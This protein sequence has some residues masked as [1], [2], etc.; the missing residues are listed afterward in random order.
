MMNLNSPDKISPLRSFLK[1]RMLFMVGIILFFIIF[2]IYPVL[3]IVGVAFRPSGRFSLSLFQ[4]MFENPVIRESIWNS[5]KIGIMVT[6]L[7]SC[8]S[9]PLA[10][11]FHRYKFP[12]KTLF[13]GLLLLPLIIPPFVGALGIRQVLAPFGSVNLWLLDHQIISNP[14]DFLGESGLFGVIFLETLHLYPIMFLNLTASLASLDPTYDEAAQNL[15]ASPLRRFFTVTLP[16]ILP[17]YF[18]GSIL[19]FLWALTDLGTPLIFDYARVMP[20]QIF[21]MLQDMN[22][23]PMGY[24]L[25]VLVLLLTLV[26]FTMGKWWAGGKSIE[27]QTRAFREHRETPLTGKEATQS[28]MVR[29]PILLMIYLY[30]LI[31]L[32][33]SIFPHLTVLMNALAGQWFMTVLPEQWTLNHFKEVFTHPLAVSSIRNSLILSF[34][35]AFLDL[36]LGVGIAWIVA[37]K[38]VQGAW[39][40]DGLVMMALT[41]PGLV[42]A[43]G[44]LACFSGT[45]L[46]ARV[47]PVP[48]LILAYGIRR[49][50][51][52]V[53]S[54]HA[55]FMQSSAAL[56]EASASLGAAASYTFRKI[57]LP[58]IVPHLLVG[59][60]LAFSFSMLEVS[61]SLILAMQEK[62]YPITKTIWYL[63]G[64]LG[65]GTSL[66]AAMG[67]LGMLLLLVTLLVAGKLLGKRLGD[68]FRVG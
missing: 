9:L 14:I 47:N 51:Y 33:I 46:D 21:N 54:A 6:V 41:V 45:F 55:G 36:V 5:F 7:A 13:Q 53:R 10:L 26:C 2:L 37:R 22:T 50:P 19:V 44:Y 27:T 18:A 59:G 56:E 16:M 67:V 40:L 35:A 48:L 29:Y 43:F 4:L 42:L 11:F 23:N 58:L 30:L 38:K 32:L 64:R 12:G 65:D 49:L 3:H 60:L 66:A 52:V 24:G 39:M 62:Y 28:W 17:G 20:M 61:D 25:V 8:V 15:G 31:V 57:T 63:S 68:I 34:A 1:G